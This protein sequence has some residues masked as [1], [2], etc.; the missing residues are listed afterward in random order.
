MASGAGQE[1]LII[2]YEDR[3]ARITVNGKVCDFMASENEI[4]VFRVLMNS[5]FPEGSE[6]VLFSSIAERFDEEYDGMSRDQKKSIQT[7]VSTALDGIDE[8]FTLKLGLSKFFIR[9]P[10]SGIRLNPDYVIGSFE[11]K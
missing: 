1:P 4:V 5:L 8:A 3:F 11:S 9:N 6:S 7:S 2:T 10:R